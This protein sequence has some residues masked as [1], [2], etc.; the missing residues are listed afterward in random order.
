MYIPFSLSVQE[1]PYTRWNLFFL[2]FFGDQS[3][4]HDYTHSSH[5]FVCSLLFLSPLY[6]ILS[7]HFQPWKKKKKKRRNNILGSKSTPLIHAALTLYHVECIYLINIVHNYRVRHINTIATDESD[8]M[9]RSMIWRVFLLIAG[10]RRFETSLK[11]YHRTPLIRM[12]LIGPVP[13]TII[14][15]S[16][17]FGTVRW[18]G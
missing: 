7:N 2:S 14:E 17:F 6:K 8:D 11:W 3:N 9:I 18:L 4:L 15:N 5:S 12:K 10:H 13:G 1:I 16:R